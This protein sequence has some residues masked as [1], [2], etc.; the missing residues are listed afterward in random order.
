MINHLCIIGVGLIGGSLA[1]ALKEQSACGRITGCGRNIDNLN[2]AIELGVIDDFSTD[3]AEA[4][5]GCDVIVL[6]V[7]MGNMQPLL[8]QIAPSLKPDAIITDV[9][10][11]KSSFLDAASH[12]F[13]ELPASLVPGHPIAGNENSGVTAALVDL[14][15]GRRVIL[16]PHENTS[17]GALSV[18]EKMWQS[19][20]AEIK[21]MDA[22]LHDHILAAT[23]HLP[24][25]LAFSLVRE[26]ANSPHHDDI[27]RYAAGGLRD[28]T[29]IAESDPVMWRDICLSNSKAILEAIE[30]YREELDRLQAAIESSDE[31]TLHTM[32]TEAHDARAHFRRLLDERERSG[33]S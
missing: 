15:Q 14:Y 3:P 21:L 29:R 23:S 33:Q 17:D 24:H 32:F 19:C 16:T 7:P 28:F 2:K 13:G 18:V 27:F 6:A 12:V 9:G 31:Q 22:A 1:L 11:A 10:S 26:L 25:M 30:R 8:E 20:G 4:V 5:R